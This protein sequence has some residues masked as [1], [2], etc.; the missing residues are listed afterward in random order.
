MVDDLLDDEELLDEDLEFQY[1]SKKKLDDAV[2]NGDMDAEDA[3]F[4]EGYQDDDDED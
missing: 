2:D 1:G 4:L 3:L